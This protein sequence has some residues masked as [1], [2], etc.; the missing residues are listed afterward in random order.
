VRS[1]L[2]A[3]AAALVVLV[4]G[5]LVL[6]AGVASAGGKHGKALRVVADQ[7]QFEFIDL[8]PAGPSLG[9]EFVFSEILSIRG[10]E[11][12]TSGG[13][14]TATAVTPPYE[15]TTFHCVATLDLGRGQVTLQGL[16]EIQGEDDTSTFT[17]AITGGT[18]AF[19][20]ASGEA[21]IRTVSETRTIYK[22]KFDKAKKKHHR[23]RH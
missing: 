21:V 18:G 2:K 15:T 14:C 20:G 8:G 17:V 7:N 9:D 5:V 1:K 23:H 22:L 4:L 13:V 6:G 11:V 12:G 19:R 10:R 16:I 3:Y